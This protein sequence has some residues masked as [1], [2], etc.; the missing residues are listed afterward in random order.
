MVGRAWSQELISFRRVRLQRLGQRAKNL[1]QLFEVCILEAH[2]SRVAEPLINPRP[3]TVRSIRRI[4]AFAMH[5]SPGTL[6]TRHLL[7]LQKSTC[8]IRYPLHC[9]TYLTEG[10]MNNNPLNQ[11]RQVASCTGF[12][13]TA[14]PDALPK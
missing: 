12:L 6:D 8:G 9:V 2:L 10:L 1:K 14:M 11:C 7:S 13:A 4:A 5:A 3:H